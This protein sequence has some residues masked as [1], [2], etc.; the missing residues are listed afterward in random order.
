M[1][2]RTPTGKDFMKT[3]E[4]RDGSLPVAVAHGAAAAAA[5]NEAA[6]EPV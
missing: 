1:G 2:N 3:D 5:A 4:I 6:T